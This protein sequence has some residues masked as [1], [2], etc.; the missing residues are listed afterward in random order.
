MESL[1]T[2]SRQPPVHTM[3]NK[4]NA[5]DAR[6]LALADDYAQARRDEGLFGDERP[7]DAAFR[8]VEA[9]RDALIAHLS[10]ERSKPPADQLAW[11]T[12]YAPGAE[13]SGAERAEARDA[14]RI[15]ELTKLLTACR[16]DM[17]EATTF[18]NVSADW[19]NLIAR[20]DAALGVSLPGGK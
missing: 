20:I 8:R 6:T 10:A 3:M 16:W 11:Q 4:L 9:A 2:L 1:D 17:Q 19:S 14:A 12:H 5:R 13:P 15:A 18:R 7:S